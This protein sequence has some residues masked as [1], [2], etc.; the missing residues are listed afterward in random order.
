MNELVEFTMRF[1]QHPELALP[2]LNLDDSAADSKKSLRHGCNLPDTVRA[3]IC[4]PSGCGKT[5][6]MLTL[7]YHPNGLRFENVYVYSKSLYQPKYEQL[8][9]VLKQSGSGLR[10]F[11][12]SDNESVIDPSE[13]REN[14][15]MIFDDVACDKQNNIKAYFSMGRHKHI[16]SFYLCQTYTC[17]PKHLVRDNANVL[18]LFKQ[19]EL[20]LRHCYDDHVTTDMSFNTFKELC[21]E[22]WKD[23]KY[24]MLVI[25]KDND[26]SQGR[27]RKNFDKYV[28]L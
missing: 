3:I 8:G 28:H 24:D 13:A 9:K 17:I 23:S 5:N 15:L 25:V 11:P 12:F 14:S 18:I 27:Y 10:Y 4:G 16:D 1:I 20:N 21:A 26:L 2:I 19:D 6:A 22:C 7:I